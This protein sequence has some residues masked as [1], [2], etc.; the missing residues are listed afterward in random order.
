MAEQRWRLTHTMTDDEGNATKQLKG[1]LPPTEGEITKAEFEVDRTKA[2]FIL[3]WADQVLSDGTAV[4]LFYPHYERR[5]TAGGAIEGRVTP[6]SKTLTYAEAKTL[7]AK[8]R[9]ETS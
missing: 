3:W 4:M 9:S 8:V 2:P 5:P 7:A 6:Q 1:Q